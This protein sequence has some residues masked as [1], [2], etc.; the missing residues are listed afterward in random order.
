MSRFTPSEIGEIRKEFPILGRYTFLNSASM[1]PLPRVSAE[2]VSALLR[3]QSEM[4]YLGMEEWKK[5]IDK[6]R[7]LAADIIG[8]GEGEVAFVRNT[9]DGVSLVASGYPWKEGD[10]V[11]IN[12]LEFP[13]NVY[14]W[15]NLERRG[16]RVR[17]V[18][19]RDGRVTVDSIAEAVTSRTRMLAISTVQFSTGFRADLAA[20]GQLAKDNGFLLFVDAIQSLGLLP[21]DVKGFGV[22]FLSCGGHKWLCAPEGIGIFFCDTDRLDSIEPTRLGWNTVV[23]SLDFGKIDFRLKPDAG[24]FEEGTV[25]LAGIYGLGESLRLIMSKGIERNMEHA[26]ALNEQLV[27]GLRSRGYKVLSP[28][29]ANERSG[30]IV[31]SSTSADENTKLRKRLDEAGVLVIER[32]GGIRV[33]PHFFNTEEDIQRLLAEL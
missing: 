26:L 25:N 11:I 18:K 3:E 17:T 22:D 2:A 24:R 21:M 5:N 4:A 12:D 31:F 15:L 8:A 14:P 7:R 16:V 10:E 28:L 30:I 23:N 27:D 33:S 13:S 20:L 32:G 29:G 1:A 6:T 9:S 19:N